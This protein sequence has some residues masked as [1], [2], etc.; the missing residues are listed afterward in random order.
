MGRAEACLRWYV[1]KHAMY[2]IHLLEWDM[3]R[4]SYAPA[5]EPH[6]QTVGGLTNHVLSDVFRSETERSGRR[7]FVG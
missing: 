7:S 2:H 6:M 3:R 5:R 4:L 1:G